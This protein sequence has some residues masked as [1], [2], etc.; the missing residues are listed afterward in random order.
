MSYTQVVSIFEDYVKYRP[1]TPPP[2]AICAPPSEFHYLKS[3]LVD[4]TSSAYGDWLI[5]LVVGCVFVLLS[6]ASFVEA[7]YECIKK[8]LKSSGNSPDCTACSGGVGIILVIVGGAGMLATSG[9]GLY[10]KY[11]CK[12]P[13]KFNNKEFSIATDHDSAAHDQD[14]E[15][16]CTEHEC[17]KM[18]YCKIK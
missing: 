18:V 17:D 12:F 14:R 5:V 15:A 11:P 8:C 2:P 7:K 9:S 10:K 6:I 13:D 16:V 3:S 1:S 4:C